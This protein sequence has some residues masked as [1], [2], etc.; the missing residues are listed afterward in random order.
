MVGPA[1]LGGAGRNDRDAEP[2]VLIDTRGPAAYQEGHI[3]G[4]V[5]LDLFDYFVDT[6]DEGIDRL[7]QDLG[8]M[9]A[10][11]GIGGDERV[12]CYEDEVGMRAAR[13][14]WLLEYAGHRDVG[15]LGG[16]FTAW[17]AGGGRP[18]T[19]PCR[20][21]PR[22]F[23][24][25]PRPEVLATAEFVNE[26]MK[27]MGE[28]GGS[29]SSLRERRT[30]ALDVRSLAEHRGETTSSHG[31]CCPRAGRIPGAVWLEWSALLTPG[32][33]AFRPPA[34]VRRLLAERGITPE[35]DIVTYCHRGA[36]A[37]AAYVALRAAGFPRVRN[38]IGSWHEWAE[39]QH[40]PV[41]SG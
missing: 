8:R 32:R 6:S 26:R 1:Q 7:N 27:E 20:P 12:I 17:L 11:A 22:R 40:L 34:D 18:C 30:V 37:A 25:A 24:I 38:Y 16:G 13:T 23:V 14:L 19:K 31:P 41:E 9:F 28:K 15:L 36:R 10:A 2:T 35:D 39:I 33:E 3:P 21:A 4:A 5:S 29:S